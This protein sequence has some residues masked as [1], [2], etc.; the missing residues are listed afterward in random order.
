VG[1]QYSN[2]IKF[3]KEVNNELEI[4]KVFVKTQIIVYPNECQAASDQLELNPPSF[5]DR[6]K[7]SQKANQF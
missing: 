6:V 1:Q 2:C 5:V 4:G 7:D 3:R